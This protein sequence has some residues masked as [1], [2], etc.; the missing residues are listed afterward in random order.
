MRASPVETINAV[1]PPVLQS[2]DPREVPV[3][4]IDIDLPAVPHDR[5]SARALRSRFATPPAWTPEMRREPRMFDRPPAQAAVLIPIV[6]RDEPTV[7]LT[8]RTTN[9][10]THSG[11]VAFPGGRVDPED[12]NI[13]AAALREAWEEVGLSA[14]YIE[15]LG[16]LP[17][18]TTVTSFIVTPV[19]ALVR[20][21]FE[22]S[23]NP[24]EVAEAFEVPFGFLM[25]P[26]N[27]RRHSLVD[28]DQMSRE[29]LSMPYQDGPHERYVW[30]AT[31]GMLRNLYRFL[32]A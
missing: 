22:L 19:V 7:L 17:T 2:F 1:I 27:H 14:Q 24:H 8:E 31:A 12:A 28:D 9:L 21:D 20:P 29:W 32:S 23:I 25:N 13:A 4:G 18:Y 3:S 11:Q 16:S 30:G 15:V 5:L 26:A 6:M 10:S